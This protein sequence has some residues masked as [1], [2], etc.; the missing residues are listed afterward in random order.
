MNKRIEA[1]P[2]QTMD[3]LTQYS[4]PGNIRELQNFIER[5]VI[6]SRGRVLDPPLAELMH[7]KNVAP[8]EPV[9][10]EDAERAHILRTLRQTN[11]QLTGAASLLGIPRTTLFYKM[12]RLGI[13]LPRTQKARN[14]AAAC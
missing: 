7:A 6:L 14:V 8:A 3:I 12:R 4:W 13:S 9:T 1:I 10:L 5:A 2:S 11:G